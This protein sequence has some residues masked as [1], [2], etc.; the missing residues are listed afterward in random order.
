MTAGDRAATDASAAELQLESRVDCGTIVGRGSTAVCTDDD[1]T[2]I[3]AVITDDKV[4]SVKRA[5]VEF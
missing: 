1:D 5:A 3:T 2:I 4:A